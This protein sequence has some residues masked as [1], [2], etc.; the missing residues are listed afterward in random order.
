MVEGRMTK[1]QDAFQ[2]IKKF[3]NVYLNLSGKTIQVEGSE[4]GVSVLQEFY[5]KRFIPWRLFEKDGE[6]FLIS[7][8]PAIDNLI[9]QGRVGYKNFI[10]IMETLRQLY[11]DLE[12]VQEVQ[13]LD[14]K[15]AKYLQEDGVILK[16]VNEGDKVVLNSGIMLK[17]N[18]WLPATHQVKY[19]R[20]G[21]YDDF[22]IEKMVAGKKDYAFMYNA[23]KGD[24]PAE[25]AGIYFVLKLKSNVCVIRRDVESSKRKEWILINV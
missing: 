20:G 13:P 10:G 4:A 22:G 18:V 21:K 8:E 23:T 17:G 7:A 9:L 14:E 2:E 5:T 24:Y 15:M 12:F 25:S 11:F 6:M 1:L 3:E 19:G 16:A